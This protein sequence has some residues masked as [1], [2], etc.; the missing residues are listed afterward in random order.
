MGG[1]RLT[2]ANAYPILTT[3]NDN[4]YKLMEENARLHAAVAFLSGY[5]NGCL[6][7]D[8][9]TLRDAK[10]IKDRLDAALNPP[11]KGLDK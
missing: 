7:A 6:K 8:D 1:K 9:I 5:L 11:Q 3:M 2:I 4:L 10:Y